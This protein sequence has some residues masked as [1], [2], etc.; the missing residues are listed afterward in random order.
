M[1]QR[2]SQNPRK[3][4]F[5]AAPIY[6]DRRLYR[7]LGIPPSSFRPERVAVAKAKRKTLPKDFESLLKTGDV[8]AL[9][10]VF[11]GCDVNARGG[12]FKQT[13]LAFND[14][15]DELARWLVDNGADCSA[16]DSYGDTPLHSR[17]GHWQG[18]IQI[19]LDLG[20]D[21]HS[22]ENGRGTPLHKAA[23][24]GNRRA[25]EL[26]LEHGA[27]V[28]ALDGSGQTPLVYALRR[29]ANSDIRRVEAV[30]QLLVAAER[31][32]VEAK[33]KSL[34]SRFLGRGHGEKTVAT[35]EIASLVERI[36]KQFEFHRA[37]YNPD[38]VEA[39]SA[40]L[41]RLYALFGVMPVP[42]RV[43]H[44]GKSPVVA[45]AARWEDRYQELWDL[46]VPSA[47]HADTVQGEVIRIA[48]RINDELER[49]GGVN[50]DADYRKMADAFLHHI[51]SAT[52]L[53][54][55]ALSEADRLI[56][57]AKARIGDDTARLRA[58]AV[59]WVALN[60]AP[61]HL[62]QPPYRR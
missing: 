57:E 44:D 19:L 7:D 54:D 61:L 14:C 4:A 51:R 9:K 24:V 10:A 56:A 32:P 40:A 11:D 3:A 39:T 49:N 58:L 15:P 46:L 48:G 47:G 2:H 31:R 29:C 27:R 1:S 60:P 43:M 38:D 25:V 33:P 30:A 34:L 37:G 53:P 17:S 59:D 42:R 45:T 8:E 16:P 52:P 62:P 28:D 6:P 18:R 22:G 20:A 36:G 23:A 13:A 41:D 50:W 55:A 35:P 21:V 5:N 12:V 26:L